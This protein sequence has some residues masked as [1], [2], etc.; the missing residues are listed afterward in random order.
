MSEWE[1]EFRNFD[2]G[3]QW[4]GVYHAGCGGAPW[5]TG[6]PRCWDQ[7]IPTNP[8]GGSSSNYKPSSWVVDFGAWLDV[9]LE[10]LKA[11]V[12][13][14]VFIGSDGENMKALVKAFSDVFKVESDIIQAEIESRKLSSEDLQKALQENLQSACSAIGQTPAS[15]AAL[16]QGMGLGASGWG[17]ITATDYQNRIYNDN[18][19]I[20]GGY[21]WTILRA[22]PSGKASVDY[23]ANHAFIQNGHMIY[24]W[25]SKQLSG[26]WNPFST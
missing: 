20:N 5:H 15:V 2:A 9:I 17:L 10:G 19:T 4:F 3:E 21:G 7:Y 16:A 23:I 12:N 22:P 24:A 1:F 8:T 6:R 18:S 11:I 13:V 25:D 26:F 14:A